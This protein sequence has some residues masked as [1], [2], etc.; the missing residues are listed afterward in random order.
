V[1]YEE[2]RQEG[3]S[4]WTEEGMTKGERTRRE[5]VQNAALLFNTRGYEGTSLSDLMAAT[6][7]QKGGI[8]RHFASKEE[9]AAEAFDYAWGKAV[10]GRLDGLAEVPNS[11]DRIKKMIAN[12]VERRTGLV[13]GGCPLLNTAIEADDGNALLRSRAK[14]A[15]QTWSGR[16]TDLVKEGKKRRE[17][18]TRTD[19]RRLSQLIIGSLEG[20]LMIS[21]IEANDG[22]LEDAQAFLYEYLEQNVRRSKRDASRKRKEV[23]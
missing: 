14:K 23:S 22:P 2:P 18:D 5:I 11:V 6:G 8:Y 12:F 15:L 13:A 10:S 1:E 17:I 4:G 21:R 16:I 20:A 19:P 3:K 7:L 9:L